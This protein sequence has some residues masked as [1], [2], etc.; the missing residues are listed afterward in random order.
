M[1]VEGGNEEEE[2]RRVERSK[3]AT[4][5]QWGRRQR[6]AWDWGEEA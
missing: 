2:R 5:Y 4:I 1:L 6:N 3:I